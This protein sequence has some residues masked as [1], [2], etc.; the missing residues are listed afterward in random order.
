MRHLTTSRLED[1]REN[2]EEETSKKKVEKKVFNRSKTVSEED[3]SVS[4]EV[5]RKKIM[6]HLTT[7]L[8]DTRENIEEETSKKKVFNR[9]KTVS[10][11]DDSVSSE[12]PRKKAKYDHESKGA[13]ILFKMG[14][15]GRG[16]GK[17]GQGRTEPIPMSTHRGREGFGYRIHEK[18]DGDLLAPEVLPQ[19]EKIVEENVVWLSADS[20]IREKFLHELRA[21]VHGWI[22]IGDRKDTLD[23]EYKYCNKDLVEKMLSAKSAFDEINA[24]VLMDARTR[25]NP[26]ETI[27]SVFFQNRAAVKMANLDRIYDWLLTGRKKRNLETKNPVATDSKDDRRVSDANIDR[28]SPLF[29]FAD[30]CAGPGGFT[31]YVL[32]RKRF[33]NAKGF[34]MTLKVLF[35]LECFYGRIHFSGKDD[36]KLNRFKAASP[37]FLERYYG[38]HG[39]GDI[40]KPENITSFEEVVKRGTNGVGV[41]LVMADGGFCVDQQENIQEILS[42]RLYLCQFL[43]GLSVLRKNSDNPGSDGRFVCKLF[44]ILTPFSVG[45]IYL[46]YITFKRISIHKPVTSRPANSERYI[47]CDSLLESYVEEIKKYMVK[48]NNELDRLSGNKERDVLEIVPESI[49]FADRK[50]KAYIVEHNERTMKKQTNSLIKYRIFAKNTSLL[51]QDQERL[52]NECLGYWEVP[53]INKKEFDQKTESL[54]AAV[55]RLVKISL[56]DNLKTRPPPFDAEVLMTKANRMRYAELRMCALS[57][58]E[59][60]VLLISIKTGIYFHPPR[61]QAEFE[62]IPLVAKIPRDTVLLVQ[63]SEFYKQLHQNGKLESKQPTIRILDAAVLCGDDVSSLSFD[64]RMAAAEKMCKAIQTESVTSDK[65]FA[66]VHVAKVNYFFDQLTEMQIIVLKLF[67]VFKLDQMNSEMER[68]HLVRANGEEIAVLKEGE[69]S[70]AF[71][72]YCR[73]MRITSLLINP[74][75]MCWSKGQKMLYAFDPTAP[76]NRSSFFSEQFKEVHCCV[77]FWKTVE[78]RNCSGSSKNDGYCWLWDWTARFEDYGPR[79]ILHMEGHTKGLTVRSMHSIIQ[80]QKLNASCQRPPCN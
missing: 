53:D 50:F 32:W 14:Y 18:I 45:L 6:R 13:E 5:P 30:I 58:R 57:E 38:K 25:A 41:D 77:D 70:S 10:E 69:E 52:R 35:L 3:D 75:I 17:R 74:W 47:V 19:E 46:M 2:V 48:I 62:K 4:N 11:E 36:F 21:A 78:I 66:V 55:G 29:Y 51:D 24:R 54:C 23:G 7:R 20:D 49:I 71:F 42:K 37:A 12:V 56:L 34:G 26:Y 31:E 68:F 22:T 63:I 60:P 44:D 1:T 59:L 16:L 80:E 28:L 40:T 67:Y 79:S 27:R 43:V 15:E 9:S 72:F 73:G 8:E 65:R 33:Y 64:D 61:S 76:R 39:D